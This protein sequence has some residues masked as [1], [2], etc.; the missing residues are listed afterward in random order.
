MKL[1]KTIVLL[2]LGGFSFAQE[3]RVLDEIVAVVGENIVLLSE[4]EAE[5]AQAKAQTQAFDGDMKCELL[6]QLVIQKLYLHKAALDSIVV[7]DD[8]VAGEVDRR[9]Q[10]Y[11]SQI[12]GEANLEKYLGKS[13]AEYKKQMSVKVREQMTTQQ[14]QQTLIANVKA[15]PTDVRKF[16]AEIP[17]DSLPTFGKEIELGVITDKPTPSDYARQYALE[18]ITGIRKSIIDG[19]YSFDIAAR[20][21]SDDKGTAVNG[22]ELGYFSRGQMVSEFERTAFRLPE[23]SISEVIETQYGF[24][25]I[26]LIDR[27]GE[28]VN[29]RHI[30]IKPLIV[31]SDLNRLKNQMLG[32]IDALEN[33]SL[34]MCQVA[35]E[36]SEDNQTKDNCG[37]YTDPTTGSTQ[38][39]VETLDPLIA[40]KAQ[41]LK[42][43]QYSAPEQYQDYDGT[44]GYR[45]FILKKEVP[46]HKAN[47]R[48][49]YQKIQTLATEKKQETTVDNW[50]EQYKSGVYV[51]IDKKYADCEEL[52]GWKGLSN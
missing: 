9:I 49:D 19:T 10:Y 28:K 22:G 46:A 42:V 34:T 35:T 31:K 16:F 13:I 20:S 6:N 36:Y 2:F 27:K 3:N 23:D 51:W 24:H 39:P 8:R 26:E 18:K 38:V 33:D 45:F 15:S 14:V 30:L 52:S 37:F 29:A 43:G 17:S 44:V 25:I 4:L 21:N 50:V 5:Y 11:A 12:G 47:L 41:T 32:L 40:A 48:D 1:L 7:G